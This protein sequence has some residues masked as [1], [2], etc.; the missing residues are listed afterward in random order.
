[1]LRL[2]LRL[3]RGTQTRKPMKKGLI[4]RCYVPLQIGAPLVLSR[5][6]HLDFEALQW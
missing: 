2:E 6:P 5:G 1:M 3:V 4:H